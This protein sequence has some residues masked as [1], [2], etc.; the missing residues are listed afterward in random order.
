MATCYAM[1][2]AALFIEIIPPIDPENPVQCLEKMVAGDVHAFSWLYKNY[3]KRLFDYVLV[4]SGDKELAEDIVHDIF[5]KLWARREKLAS[6]SN[7]RSYLFAMAKNH[8]LNWQS[9][10]KTE[11]LVTQELTNF[12]PR[13]LEDQIL[14]REEKKILENAVRSLTQRQ[15]LVFKLVKEE[16]LSRMEVSHALGISPFTVKATVQNALKG[17]KKKVSESMM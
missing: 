17:I 15:K 1:K 16:G 11:Q 6:I 2:P 14:K 10:R 7:L 12:I 5:L 4:L 8:F 3:R 13:H 9:K